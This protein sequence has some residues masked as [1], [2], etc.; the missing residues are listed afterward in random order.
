VVYPEPEL[1]DRL[2]PL[3]RDSKSTCMAKTMESHFSSW[4]IMGLVVLFG[5]AGLGSLL[6]MRIDPSKSNPPSDPPDLD[7]PPS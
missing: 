7:V 4:A 6:A 3:V 5:V 2:K 1:A